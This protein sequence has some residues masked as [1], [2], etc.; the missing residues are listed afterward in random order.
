MTTATTPTTPTTM[1][2]SKRM[3]RGMAARARTWATAHPRVAVR[4][5]GAEDPG[6]PMLLQLQS[7]GGLTETLT[8]LGQRW[9]DVWCVLINVTLLTHL[10]LCLRRLRWRCR[11][12]RCCGMPVYWACARSDIL[13][14]NLFLDGGVCGCCLPRYLVHSASNRHEQSAF[15]ELVDKTNEHHMR[16]IAKHWGR[17]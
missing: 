10:A 9:S 14:L 13:D 4:D 11:S 12:S 3:V 16:T 15:E 5:V 7:E 2:V 1:A 6:R 17:K 8:L